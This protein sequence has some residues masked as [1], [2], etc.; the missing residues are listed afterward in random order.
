MNNG[1]IKLLTIT[2]RCRVCL[3]TVEGHSPLNLNVAQLVKKLPL[4]EYEGSLPCLQKSIIQLYL[5]ELNPVRNF[6]T[7]LSAIHFTLPSMPRS[8]IGLFP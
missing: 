3:E 1:H 5:E 2:Q 6:T 8:P 4:Y 7:Y